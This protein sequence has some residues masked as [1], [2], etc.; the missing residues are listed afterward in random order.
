MKKYNKNTGIQFF[1][2]KFFGI[3]LIV[4]SSSY[5]VKLHAQADSLTNHFQNNYPLDLKMVIKGKEK[6][7]NDSGL[8]QED[9]LM[10]FA[11]PIVGSNPTL[12]FFYGLGGTGS[13]YLGDPKTTNISSASVNFQYTTNNQFI[14]SMRGTVMTADNS[15]ELLV[16]LRYS[17]FSE[18]TYGLGSDYNQPINEEWNIGGIEITGV[19][20]AQPIESNQVRVHFTALNAITNRLFIGAGYHLDYHYAIDDL[21]LDLDATIPVITSHYAYSTI[22]GFDPT[23]YLSSGL[24]A[25]IM[26]DDRDHTVNTYEGNFIHL[27]Y[28]FNPKFLGS[29]TDYQ[30]IYAEGRVFKPLSKTNPRHLLAFWGIGQFTVSGDAPY[31]HLPFSGNDMRNRIG[32]GYVVGRFRGNSWITAE[33]EYRYPISKNGLLSGVVFGNASTT[34]RAEITIGTENLERL[35]LFEAIRPAGGAGLRLLLERAGRLNLG[36]DYAIGQNGSKG[37]YFV[38]GETF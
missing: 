18:Y 21:S 38:I 6:S 22:Y 1:N 32:R 12:G 8:P 36:L 34:S 30:M 33:A 31:L 17:I 37:L 26:I 29:E 7:K 27:S 19:N 9:K 23:N 35:R 24:S 10:W 11:V 13:I 28:R 5:L 20:G 16:D 15:W 25:D 3:L 2:V 4:L 14:S